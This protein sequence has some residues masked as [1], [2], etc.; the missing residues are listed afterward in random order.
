[1]GIGLSA[2]GIALTATVL[3]V[4]WIVIRPMLPDLQNR[5]DDFDPSIWI[6]KPVPEM[7]F[8][9]LDG[10]TIHTAD[11]KGHPVVVD[12][13]GSWH[14]A[15][16]SAVPDF[17]RLVNETSTQGV[18][19]VAMTFENAADLGEY[20]TN[21]AIN[22]PIVASTNLPAPFG[23]VDSIPTTFFINAQ[24][25]IRDIRSG[26]ECYDNL[27]EFALDRTPPVKVKK[28]EAEEEKDNP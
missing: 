28:E 1:M 7:T 9:A 3:A 21:H 20:A 13:W 5:G 17:I 16:T 12:M 4:A 24:G 22:Y 27:K 8:T 23:K 14:P 25:I 15:C 26:Y 2:A 18:R 19:V 11:W 10:R 6:G